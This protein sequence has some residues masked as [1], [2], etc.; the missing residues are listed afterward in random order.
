MP[1]ERHRRAYLN[2]IATAQYQAAVTAA[3]QPAF[4]RLTTTPESWFL[5]AAT[6]VANGN[7]S[8]LWALLF[9]AIATLLAGPIV[10]LAICFALGGRTLAHFDRTLEVQG[11]PYHR[12]DTDSAWQSYQ[13]RLAES[14]QAVVDQSGRM[15]RERD[16]LF[17]GL[18]AQIDYPILLHQSILAE[19]AHITGDSG[20]GK[21]ALGIPSLLTQLTGRPGSSI[22]VIDLKGDRALFECARLEAERNRIPFRWVTNSPMDATFAFNPFLQQH[23]RKI[24][25]VQLAEVLLKSLG[26]EYGEGYGRSYFSSLH[27]DVLTK[28]L[29]QYP[30]INSFRML[31]QY[32]SN[33]R[34]FIDMTREQRERG[35][36]LLTT[37]NM[38]STMDA[39]NITPDNGCDKEVFAHR[40]DMS[41][42]IARPQVV[43]FYLHAQLQ[44]VTMREVAK[45]ALHSLLTAA[46]LDKNRDHQVYLFVDE[47]QQ[48]VSA[49][50]E[51][52]LRMARDSGIA[53]ILCNQTISDLVTH[54]ADLRPTVQANTRFKQIF[55]A[56]DL[57]QQDDIIKSSGE[58]IY[59]MLSETTNAH[60]RTTFAESIGPRLRR[61]D[62]IETSDNENLSI[63][64]VSRGRGY[65]QF[66]GFP[67]PMY[68]A[69]HIPYGDYVQRRKRPWPLSK[70]HAGAYVPPTERQGDST[71]TPAAEPPPPAAQVRPSAPDDIERG[72]IDDIGTLLDDM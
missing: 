46:V 72:R 45:L 53:A 6:Q 27:R 71:S 61:N 22:V 67:F 44:E 16:H 29:D 54:A 56:T 48:I 21:S 42:V 10:F 24:T 11:A 19:H 41:D 60:T 5:V 39:L 12:L 57:L 40:I 64:H 23:M 17:I 49:D 43:Y 15:V 2:Q 9:S 31:Q 66:G 26:L 69:F 35:A 7:E 47:F 4:E 34:E 13:K 25:R 8:Y 58:A 1:S 28:L 30:E 36:H 18:H 3:I 68:T 59:G 65:T 52:V 38:L 63:A 50:L 62:V 55:S 37:V 14:Q 32:L 20:S 51:I 33:A 70:D